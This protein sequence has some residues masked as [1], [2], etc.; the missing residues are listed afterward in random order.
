MVIICNTCVFCCALL[1]SCNELF[2]SYLCISLHWHEGNRK[3]SQAV[4]SGRLTVTV[5]RQSLRI[6][7]KRKIKQNEVPG[8]LWRTRHRSTSC[9]CAIMFYKCLLW[10]SGLSAIPAKCTISSSAIYMR[11]VRTPFRPMAISGSYT[12]CLCIIVTFIIR[13]WENNAFNE[14]H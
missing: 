12:R 10:T 8:L 7:P 13:C 2:Y 1:L 6:W 9:E 14:S 3:D 11:A 5:F 4:L